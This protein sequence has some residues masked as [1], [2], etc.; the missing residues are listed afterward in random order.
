MKPR[1]RPALTLDKPRIGGG[2]GPDREEEEEEERLYLQLETRER[3]A[4]P[5]E[6][7]EV[8]GCRNMWLRVCALHL[9]RAVL[10]VRCC[11]RSC[12]AP[13]PPEGRPGRKQGNVGPAAPPI[14]M[15]G[16]DRAM[17]LLATGPPCLY[18]SQ[19]RRPDERQL[20]S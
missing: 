14:E 13:H 2:S 17:S 6:G 9:P 1:L 8:V 15:G 16:R 18:T 20:Y 4:P 10:E 11:Y 3:V 5:R 19:L 12:W 7:E